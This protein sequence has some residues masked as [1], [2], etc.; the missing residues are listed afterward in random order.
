MS[1]VLMT[2][3]AVILGPFVLSINEWTF[4]RYILHKRWWF[5]EYPFRAHHVIHHGHFSGERYL[6]QDRPA[7]EVHHDRALI[8]MAI[9]SFLLVI[10]AL[11]LPF[12]VVSV[13]V[14]F[15]WT[16]PHGIAILCVGVFYATLGY[17]IYEFMHWCMHNP[18]GRK[19]E[20]WRLFRWLDAHHTVHH[21]E[22]M[23]NLNVVFPFADWLFGT[24]RKGKTAVVV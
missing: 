6:L 7:A 18:I 11:S 17:V 24:L 10:P 8:T 20:R 4:H 3:V 22:P 9:W 14:M 23:T 16:V 1:L 13:P 21:D 5:L 2:I 12:L 15:F 19:L